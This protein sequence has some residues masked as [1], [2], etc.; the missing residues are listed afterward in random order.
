MK[1]MIT[2]LKLM[3]NFNMAQVT[4]CK[5]FLAHTRVI[6][7]T[8]SISFSDQMITLASKIANFLFS[9]FESTTIKIF[10]ILSS[11]MLN[12]YNGSHLHI[13]SKSFNGW[14]WI[15]WHAKIEDITLFQFLL[16]T[17]FFSENAR[18]YF[19]IIILFQKAFFQMLR[20]SLFWKERF[21]SIIFCIIS[22]IFVL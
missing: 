9:N 20:Q 1:I 13:H 5:N 8:L 12:F 15:V 17:K 7:T 3:T 19:Q 2:W 11:F 22:I 18:F 4:V 14:N 16:K 21:A 10:F 6:R